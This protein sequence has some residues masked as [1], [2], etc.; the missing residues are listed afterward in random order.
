MITNKINDFLNAFAGLFSA[1]W[2][3]DTVTVERAEGFFLWP[4]GE[5]QRVRWYRMEDETSLEDM[6]RLCTYLTRNKWVR[7]DKIIINEEELLQNLRD[8]KI[9]KAPAQDV[10]EHLLQT[11]IKMIDEGEETDSFFLHF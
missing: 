9:L 11:E 8:N 3:P 7:S 6:T 10:W 1:K 2:E 5:R 4:D